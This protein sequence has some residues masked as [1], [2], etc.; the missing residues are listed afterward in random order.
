MVLVFPVAAPGFTGKTLH[1]TGFHGPA[2]QCILEIRVLPLR[3][4]VRVQEEGNARPL[5][6]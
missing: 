1:S 6:R 2:G 4:Q 5:G 3:R